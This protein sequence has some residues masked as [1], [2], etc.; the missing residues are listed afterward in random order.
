MGRHPTDARQLLQGLG[1]DLEEPCRR[2]AIQE[3]LESFRVW[4]RKRNLSVALARY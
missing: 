1:M 2:R 3:G 4:I